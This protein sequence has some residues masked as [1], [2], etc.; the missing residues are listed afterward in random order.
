MTS[1][2]A[3]AR[4]KELTDEVA[5]R[6][7]DNTLTNKRINEIE[8]EAE[9]LGIQVRNH[10]A[11]LGLAGSADPYPTGNPTDGYAPPAAFGVQR[12][13][14]PEG[15]GSN[16]AQLKHHA[17]S[18]YDMTPE[19]LE[20]LFLAGKSAQSFS[21]TIDDRGHRNKALFGGMRDKSA[22]GEGAS[23]TLIP[24]ILL[25]NA[26]T[27]RVEPTRIAEYFPVVESEGQTVS[28]IQ[29]T[30]N[31][32]AASALAVAENAQKSDISPTLEAFDA[33]YT[34]VAGL[35]KVSK[36][37]FTDFDDVASFMPRELSNWIIQ[38]ENY[39]L[40]QGNGTSPNQTGLFNTTGTLT[41]QYDSIGGDTV[42]DTVLEAVTDIREGGAYAQADLILLHPTDWL[43]MRKLKTTFNSYVLDPNDPNTLGGIDNLFGIRVVVS[44]QV[45]QSHA[46]V[47][48]SKI[49][50]NVFHRW[51]LEVMAN[52]YADSAFEFN[53]IHYRA[54]TRFALGVIYPEAIC[55][56][57][58]TDAA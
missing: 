32:V 28:W 42:I 41:R 11:A 44:T 39:Q 19:Q 13:Q 35:A 37:L 29:H 14:L 20:S 4:L 17:P 36:Q 12:W 47:L 3:E 18:P 8:A 10:K 22:I 45:P 48:D 57:N 16:I 51:G 38:G 27:M 5:R 54:E 56:V 30:Q 6:T 21:T 25:P 52:P 55:L 53:Q 24:L 26:F 50:C 33:T 9:R 7:L 58:L 31:A 49:A 40:L 23:G 34:V 46:A 43:A 15:E 2:A 1:H